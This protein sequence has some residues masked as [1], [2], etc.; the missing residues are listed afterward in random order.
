MAHLKK[1]LLVKHSPKESHGIIFRYQGFIEQ[2]MA[3]YHHQSE[4]QQYGSWKEDQSGQDNHAKTQHP[5]YTEYEKIKMD[6][7]EPFE[8]CFFVFR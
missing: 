2:I 3:G 1:F 5:D 4:D 6:I 8:S 7:K